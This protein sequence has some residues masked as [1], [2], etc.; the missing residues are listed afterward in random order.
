M[1]AMHLCVQVKA[2]KSACQ[3]KTV[4]VTRASSHQVLLQVDVTMCSAVVLHVV[5]HVHA[6]DTVLTG[7]NKC[8]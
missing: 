1:L 7:C 5:R 2:S 3:L 8:L 6:G 4:E